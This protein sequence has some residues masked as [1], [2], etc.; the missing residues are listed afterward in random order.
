MKNLEFGIY[1]YMESG[2]KVYPELSGKLSIT[3]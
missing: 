2:R 1:P 3:K